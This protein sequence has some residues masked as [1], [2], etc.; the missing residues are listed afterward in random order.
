[1]LLPT[2]YDD[3]IKLLIYTRDPNITNDLMKTLTAG[4][5]KIRVMRKYNNQE[6]ECVTYKQISAGIVTVGDKVNAINM[7]LLS[8]R[9]SRLQARL[10]VTEVI[11]M[12]VG[13][14]LAVLASFTGLWLVP[15]VALA[16]WQAGWCGVLHFISCRNFKISKDKR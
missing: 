2:L 7:I 5:D 12:A 16:A 13:A 1:M 14:A 6:D 3:G 10:A 8:K 15:S 9:Y 11:A 4:T